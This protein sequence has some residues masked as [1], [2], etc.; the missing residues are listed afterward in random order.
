V[1]I[2]GG[3]FYL[4]NYWVKLKNRIYMDRDVNRLKSIDQSQKIKVKSINQ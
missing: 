2:N 3:I 4:F 1:Y